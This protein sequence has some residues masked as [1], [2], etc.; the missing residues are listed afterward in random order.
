PCNTTIVYNVVVYGEEVDARSQ[1]MS[2]HSLDLICGE[3]VPQRLC[4]SL[5][6]FYGAAV[7]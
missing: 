3:Q 4:H 2:V 5:M 6:E 1:A 7:A